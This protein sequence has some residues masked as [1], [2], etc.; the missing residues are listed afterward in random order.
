MDRC[1]D[2]TLLIV[3]LSNPG[4]KASGSAEGR[5]AIAIL[6]FQMALESVL[7]STHPQ[8]KISPIMSQNTRPLI[9]LHPT[10][11]ESLREFQ[12][13]QLQHPPFSLDT[14]PSTLPRNRPATAF[15]RSNSRSPVESSLLSAV[16]DEKHQGK[17]EKEVQQIRYNPPTPTY[18]DDLPI[19]PGF[20]FFE[21]LINTPYADTY[22]LEIN[23]P[24]TLYFSDSELYILW[25]GMD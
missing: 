13:L 14:T 1:V 11:T 9:V 19:K 23:L 8:G 21:G 22:S 18:Y 2:G 7:E 20:C 25:T 5:T 6:L 10:S 15:L 17:W 3:L 12:P 16:W 24:K 4:L